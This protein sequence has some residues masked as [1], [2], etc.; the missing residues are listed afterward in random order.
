MEKPTE[1]RDLTLADLTAL[2]YE[3]DFAYRLLHLLSQEDLLDHYLRRAA[4]A[5]CVPIARIGQDYPAV[6]REKLD[7]DSPASLWSK[8]D[9][10]IL[11]KPRIALVGS[12]E[13][14]QENRSFAWEVGTQAALQG[15]VLVSGNARGAD[16]IAQTACL[17]AG[18]QVIVVVAD[19]L[20][21]QKQEKNVLYISEDGFDLP[22]SAIRALSRNRVIHALAEKTFVAQC[23]CGSGGTWD[24]TIKNLNSGW[25]PVFC[26]ADGTPAM[27]QLSQMGA[28]KIGIQQLGDIQQLISARISLFDQ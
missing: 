28:E 10:S 6:L 5:G 15:Y 19:E 27:E 16:K 13:I 18:G 12:R 9:L 22:F 20:E 1:Q 8:G 3:Q 24:G 4:A 25:S 7:P 14:Q 23:T 17:R 21:K 2:G 11:A 26:F